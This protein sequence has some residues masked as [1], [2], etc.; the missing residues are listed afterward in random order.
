LH[1]NNFSFLMLGAT[2]RNHRI[3]SFVQEL[4]PCWIYENV[5]FHSCAGAWLCLP[6][7]ALG[8]MM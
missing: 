8:E 1:I 3:C 5:S 4:N 7:P 6:F 2:N